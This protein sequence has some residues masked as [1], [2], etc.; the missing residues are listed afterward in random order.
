[1][2]KLIKEINRSVELE[3]DVSILIEVVEKW[4]L[5]TMKKMLDKQWLFIAQ[6]FQRVILVVYTFLIVFTPVALTVTAYAIGNEMEFRQYES[7]C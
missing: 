3:E 2:V 6:V 4:R 7:N 1:M 5:F